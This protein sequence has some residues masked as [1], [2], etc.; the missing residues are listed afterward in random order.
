MTEAPRRTRANR[1]VNCSSTFLITGG[2]LAARSS[3]GPSDERRDAAFAAARPC[4]ELSSASKTSAGDRAEML[5][6]VTWRVGRSGPCRPA[7]GADASVVTFDDGNNGKC[8]AGRIL[9]NS[10]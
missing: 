2:R 4:G 7:G 5:P 8:R 9:P 10:A 6:A 3:L 1:L